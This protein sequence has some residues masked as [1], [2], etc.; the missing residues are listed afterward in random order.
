MSGADPAGLTAAE[1]ARRWAAHGP[2]ELP[3]AERHGW[4]VVVIDV[5]REPMFILRIVGALLYLAVGEVADGV[6]LLV[7]VLCVIGLTLFQ[8]RRT[9][10]ALEALSLLAEPSAR[11]IRDGVRRRIPARELTVGD[12]VELA[13]GERIPADALLR[14]TSHFAVDESLLTGESVPVIKRPSVTASALTPLGADQGQTASLFAGTLVTAGQGL[15]EV[16]NVGTGTELARMG[17]A[18]QNI[19]IERTPLQR[20][21]GRVVR[22][23]AAAGLLACVLV[24]VVYGLTRGGDLVAWKQGALAGIAMAMSVLPEE[25]A[26]VLTI[27]LALGAWRMS[28]RNVLTRR[29]PVIEALGAATVLCVDKTGTLTENRMALAALWPVGK[30]SVE[31]AALTSLDNAYAELLTVAAQAATHDSFDPMD[32]SLREERERLLGADLDQRLLREYPLSA[33]RA[34]VGCVWQIGSAGWTLA[35]KGAPEVIA[36]LCQLS[37]VERRRVEDEVDEL[38][39]QGLRVLAVARASKVAPDT[40]APDT[41]AKPSRSLPQALDDV[42]LTWLGLVAFADPLRSSVPDAVQACHRAGIRVVMITGDYPLT[43]RTIAAQAGIEVSEVRTGNELASW[44]DERLQREI[45]QINVFARVAPREKLRLVEAL[46]RA[47]EVVAMTGDGVND[48]PALKAAHIGI[49]MGE[50]GTQVAREAAALI[51]LDDAFESIV[52]AIAQGRR[53]YANIVKASRFILAVHIPIA[54][55]SMLPVLMGDWPLILLPV[56]IV[57]LEFI[58]DPACALIF[59]AERE[60][61]SGMQRPP[62]PLGERLFSRHMVWMGVSQ[63]LSLWVACSL[64]FGFYWPR[65]GAES[66]RTLGFV[67]LVAGVLTM[68]LINRSESDSVWRK[69]REWNLALVAVAGAAVVFLTVAVTLAPVRDLFSFGPVSAGALAVVVLTAVSV[70]MWYELIKLWHGSAVTA[71]GTPP[72]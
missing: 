45:G 62:R 68:I 18:L 21:T 33:D 51:L 71:A 28:R 66:A 64:V 61:K 53:I 55:L 31:P 47:G 41:L 46:K 54:G 6:L 37:T 70:L 25:F 40:A 56:H 7:C 8:S 9:E 11:V 48:A 50:R 20:E 22:K 2:N 13:E 1:A 32:R 10:R 69:L 42:S 38:A 27:F 35:L 43:A 36:Q 23:M 65:V 29:F 52:V 58:I 26:V 49:A 34:A 60:E 5:L 16:V 30:D 59:E 63:G 72:Q 17:L 15:A 12:V 57:F 67:A 39:A 44:D 14:R 19:E 24:V 4:R 3:S